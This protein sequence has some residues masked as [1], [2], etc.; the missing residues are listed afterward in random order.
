MLYITEFFNKRYL[1]K[2]D[3]IKVDSFIDDLKTLKDIKQIF[4]FNN[5][6]IYTGQFKKGYR[7]GKGK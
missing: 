3:N 5:G 2:R 4:E 1:G 7:H 6:A